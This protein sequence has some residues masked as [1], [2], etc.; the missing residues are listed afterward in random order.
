MLTGFCSRSVIAARFQSLPA[1]FEAPELQPD[2]Y[3]RQTTTTT[4]IFS[5]EHPTFP[6]ELFNTIKGFIAAASSLPV[7]GC[8]VTF[9]RRTRYPR[10][11]PRIFIEMRD[12]L[13]A[14]PHSV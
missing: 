12:N 2:I 10:K 13:F 1:F 4:S 7:A 14:R 11:A 3:L 5:D 8:S 9:M 6:T